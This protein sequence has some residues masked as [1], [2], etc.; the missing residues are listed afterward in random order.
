MKIAIASFRDKGIRVDKTTGSFCCL[1]NQNDNRQIALEQT[2][3]FIVLTNIVA[4]NA[5]NVY[6]SNCDDIPSEIIM[7]V[8]VLSTFFFAILL[9]VL[10]YDH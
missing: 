5:Q 10:L 9:Y 7:T 6:F 3:C 4:M 8:L 2:T 1:P